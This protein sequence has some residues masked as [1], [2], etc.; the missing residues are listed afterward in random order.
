MRAE[1]EIAQAQP[2]ADV[3]GAMAL[4]PRRQDERP[5]LDQHSRQRNVRGDH[6]IAFRDLFHDVAVGHVEP[7][8]YLPRAYIR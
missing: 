1:E 2:F 6:Q 3:F 8:R 5:F 4:A 7:H